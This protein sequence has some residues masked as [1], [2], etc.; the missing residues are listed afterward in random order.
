MTNAERHF[1][2]VSQGLQ[3]DEAA[4]FES[5]VSGTKTSILSRIAGDPDHPARPGVLARYG[6]TVIGH[7]ERELQQRFL[8]KTPWDEVKDRLVASSPFLQ[9]APAHWAER[10]V[11]TEVMNASNRSAWESIRNADEQLGDACKILSC[12]IDFR[13]GADSIAV[14]GQ[15]RKVEEAFES[16]FGAFQHPPDRPNDRATVVPH[17]VSWPIPDYLAPR[18]D[19]E[20]ASRWRQEGRKGSPP[21]RP[22]M[23]TID[24]K[25]FGVTPPPKLAAATAEAE[26]QVPEAAPAAAPIVASMLQTAPQAPPVAEQ[27]NRYAELDELMRDRAPGEERAGARLP[28]QTVPRFRN[29]AARQRWATER[30]EQLPRYPDHPDDDIVF[31]RLPTIVEP[32]N[33]R[34]RERINDLEEEIRKLE[35]TNEAPPLRRVRIDQMKAQWPDVRAVHV[36]EDIHNTKA[37]APVLVRKDGKLFVQSGLETVIA[38]DLSGRATVDVHVIDLD[39]KPK[40]APKP[41]R[42]KVEMA[43]DI[44]IERIAPADFFKHVEGKKNVDIIEDRKGTAERVIARVFGDKGAPSIATFEK[45]YGSAEHDVRLNR[46]ALHSGAYAI[47]SDA[48]AR[49]SVR[50][51]GGI[52]S[53]K[54]NRIGEVT[55]TFIRHGDGTLEVHHDYFRIEGGDERGKGTGEAMLRQSLQ[56]YEHIG[57]NHVT[58]DAAWVGQ[59][60]WATFGYNWDE[61]TADTRRR[62]L[63]K[64]LVR[65]G[66]IDADRAAKIAK[67]VAPR[68]WDVAA[69]DVDGILVNARAQ[70]EGAKTMPMKL[71]KAFLLEGDMWSGSLSL[72]KNSP[73]YKRAKERLKL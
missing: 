30:L 62:D 69:L 7:F 18:S 72:D 46:V 39:A 29:E 21:A 28:E 68:A 1:R 42:V 10:I 56:A 43:G 11:R 58:V 35:K 64:Y 66:G 14:H 53:K 65:R 51:S 36:L 63:A 73:T 20:V 50:L 19:G 71:G 70:I 31:H 8:A 37:P 33:D 57:V 12:G 41:A 13:T 26:P 67:E 6:T 40:K 44:P 22:L 2:G 3:L 52:Y 54:G 23:S 32:F 45:I 5:A 47:G 59:Y 34:I 48:Q 16:W 27:P 38:H 9:G 4:M 61:Y 49:A 24:R 55:R 60:T 17:R 25:L 15:I